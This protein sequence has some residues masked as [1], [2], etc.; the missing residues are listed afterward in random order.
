MFCENCGRQLLDGE[1]CTCTQQTPVTSEQPAPAPQAPE[2][3]Q[4]QLYQPQPQPVYQPTPEP[5]PAPAP[6]PQP[7]YQ[8]PAPAPA[9]APQPAPAYQP[10]QPSAYQPVTK[11]VAEK[12]SSFGKPRYNLMAQL[13]SSPVILV[14]GILYTASILFQLISIASSFS[15][16]S[17]I[18]LILVLLDSLVAVGAFISW[19][20]AKSYISKSTPISTAG[21]TMASGLFKAY[22][23]VYIVFASIFT[24]IILIAC[25]SIGT[26]APLILLLIPV[27]LIFF[28][29]AYYFSLSNV[30]KAVRHEISNHYYGNGISLYPVVIKCIN[31]V[32][33]VIGF[34]FNIVIL[35]AASSI[36]NS[37]NS[38]GLLRDMKRYLGREVYDT[39]MEFLIPSSGAIAIT[40]IT[41]LVGLAISVLAIAILIKARQAKN[42]TYMMKE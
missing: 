30:L 24:L 6:A 28:K 7:V 18:S 32:F 14:F 29:I 25:G 21:L 22:G 39:I 15:F 19:G 36:M 26:S 10:V 37:L 23:I 33:Q 16:F 12:P 42:Q 20:S 1:V 41:S 27:A 17:I 5:A 3:P 2:A 9:P 31:T 8:Q 40:I 38:Y 34:I 11:P 35:F 13:L 4:P